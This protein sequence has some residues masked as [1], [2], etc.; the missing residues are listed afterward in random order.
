M[1]LESYR[2]IDDKFIGEIERTTTGKYRYKFR[3]GCNVSLD[4]WE[5]LMKSAKERIEKI[6]GE[7]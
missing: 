6:V 4:E 7:Q 3:V 5:I 1:T 2:K